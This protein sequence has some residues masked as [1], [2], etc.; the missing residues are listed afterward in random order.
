MLSITLALLCAIAIIDYRTQR[1]P[2]FL[3]LLFVA[4]ALF[5]TYLR[6]SFSWAALSI[7]TGFFFIQW[8]F[9]RGRFIGSGDVLL[10]LGV[11]F[12]MIDSSRAVLFLLATY[13]M[14][15]VYACVSLLCF[16]HRRGQ[17]IAFAPFL[18]VGMVVSLVAPE[19]VLLSFFPAF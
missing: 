2:D 5:T 11:S 15:G 10:S 16:R 3:N 4:S 14:G 17:R 13:G 19:T 1:I 9:S 18:F 12:L 6:G 8:I 7:V